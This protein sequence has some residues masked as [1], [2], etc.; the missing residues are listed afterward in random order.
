MRLLATA[1]AFADV[2][3]A[4]VVAADRNL[5]VNGALSLKT[6]ERGSRANVSSLSLSLFRNPRRVSL[7]E[8]NITTQRDVALSHSFS[9]GGGGGQ[10][11]T[12]PIGAAGER[13]AD[14]VCDERHLRTKASQDTQRQPEGATKENGPVASASPARARFVFIRN[15][16]EK[17]PSSFSETR[18]LSTKMRF[19]NE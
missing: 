18:A 11:E 14:D 13:G 1:R 3:P 19:F 12:H 5:R 9:E 15:V 16:L 8:R 6:L 7:C 10:I 17:T 4:A 2:G